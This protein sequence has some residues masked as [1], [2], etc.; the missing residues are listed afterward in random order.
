MQL[1]NHNH[2][3]VAFDSLPASI[4]N[5]DHLSILLLNH[6]TEPLPQMRPYLLLSG[7]AWFFGRAIWN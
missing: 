1:F 6:L 2:K 3:R 5:D 7:T 4:K